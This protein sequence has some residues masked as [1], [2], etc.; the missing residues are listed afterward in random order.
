MFTKPEHGWTNL[1]LGD[2]SER[3]S[4]LMDIPNDCLDA[5]IYAIQN[6]VPAAVYFDAEGWDFHLISSYYQT[7]IILDK[8][9]VKTF[10]IDKSFN[11]LAKEL[12]DD[13]ESYFNEWINWECYRDE[14]DNV[15]INDR[16]NTLDEKLSILK[17]LIKYK[18]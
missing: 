5:F 3:A 8:D 9:N 2:F 17:S 4:Y 11:E 6:H 7:Y 14:D 16:K 18:K 10:L 13:I 12:I 15:Y 1:Q